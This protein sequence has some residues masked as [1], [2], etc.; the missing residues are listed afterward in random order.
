MDYS[1]LFKLLSLPE[2]GS[3]IIDN[4]EIIAD[5]K[6]VYISRPAVPVYCPNCSCRM[7]SKGIYKRKIKHPVLQD[8]TCI[9]F[10]VSQRKWKCTNCNTY[11]NES[12]PFFK[13]YKQS[14][15]ITPLMIL[16]AMKDLDRTTASIARQY[17]LSD[18]QV[19]DIF[20]AYIDLPRL[21][22]PEFLSVDEVHI[23]ISEEEKYALV[24]MDFCTG[25]IIDIL[26]NRWKST[27]EDYFYS[28]PFEERK[29]VRFIIS[30]AYQT[31]IDYPQNFFP[32][33][34][35]VLDS[36]HVIKYLNGLINTY[37]NIVMKS[38]KQLDKERLDQLNHD[39]NGDNKSI[40]ESQEVTLL[41]KY[42]WVLLKNQDDINYSDRR[43]YHRA[44]GI[45]ADTYTIEKMF[46]ELD[47]KFSMIRDAKEKY[48]RFN[49]SWFDSEE[50]AIAEI[51]KLID[52]FKGSR[53]YVPRLF[54]DYL[55][56]YKIEIARSF[57][58]TEVSRRSS[59]DSERYYSRLSNGPMESF[60]R[61]PK[62]YKRNARGFSNFNYTR[63]R[64]LWSTRNKPAIRNTPKPPEEIHSYRGKERGKYKNNK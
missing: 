49:N 39:I 31:Y 10:I 58:V 25:Q 34:V 19:H 15:D 29:H 52:E 38:Y 32:N 46:L 12:F 17:H 51:E 20:S 30:D 62:D 27:A 1:Y 3:I 60:N 18:T 48:I 9:V 14:S 40:K 41:R 22:L 16:N 64:I 43:H 45:Y 23:D 33:A 7:H 59:K 11:L 26:H 61:K 36:F 5:T 8:S 54:A 28:I 6:F 55:K 56:K 35:S 4:V 53:S 57:T 13:P 47:G 24:L 2:D 42:R 50:S 44:L 63:N 37:I 21:E